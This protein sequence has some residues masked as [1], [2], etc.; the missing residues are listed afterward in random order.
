[1]T[2]TLFDQPLDLLERHFQD[3]QERAAN[4]PEASRTGFSTALQELSQAIAAL[5]AGRA[6][7]ASPPAA[8]P[9]PC[10]AMLRHVFN[11]IPDLLTIHDRDFNT[12]MSNWHGYESVPEAERQ[13]PAQVLPGLPSPGPPLRGLPC[14]GGLGHGPTRQSGKGQAHRRPGP[15]S[16]S[17]PHP[18]R[19]RPGGPG[20]GAR[21]GRHRA[22]PGGAGPQGERRQIPDPDRR[23]SGIVVPDR[24][25]GNHPG[26]QPGSS[27]ETRKKF[28]RD[29]RGLTVRPIPPGGGRPAPGDV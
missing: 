12:I 27:P 19:I 23:Q 15:G 21:A 25:S 29:H 4:L 16:F 22:P 2:R 28:N 3:L 18:G 6:A 13:A 26:R 11:A 9:G 5:R 14:P 8:A 24:Y 10:E 1:M 7:G 17:L 20:G